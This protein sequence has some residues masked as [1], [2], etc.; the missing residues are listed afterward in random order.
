[1]MKVAARLVRVPAQEK[2]EYK[3]NNITF[4]LITNIN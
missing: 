3:H 1:M 4:L 2:F